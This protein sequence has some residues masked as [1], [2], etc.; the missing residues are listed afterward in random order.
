MKNYKKILIV[1]FVSL[2]MK[3]PG[4]AGYLWN[5]D[6]G[7][8]EFYNNNLEFAKDYFLSYLNNNP[9]DADGYWWL[10]NTLKKL[11][12]KKYLINFKKSYELLSKEKNLEKLGF[13][14]K[15]SANIEDYFDMAT[16]YFDNGNLKEAEFYADMMLRINPKSSS[17]YYIKA[18]V[19]NVMQDDIKAKEYMEKA[20][21]Y[22]NELIKTNLAQSLGITT[23]PQANEK[24]M[25][26]FSLESYF[27]GNLDE[28]IEY[29]KKANEI[30]PQDAEIASTLVNLYFKKRNY[31]PVSKVLDTA[32]KANENNISLLLDKSDLYKIEKN[33]SAQLNTLLKA[34]KINPNNPNVLLAL[35]NFYFENK[36]YENAKKYFETLSIVDD[37]MYEGIFGLAE[38][39][40]NLG[41]IEKAEIEVRKLNKVN[42][43]ASEISYLLSK[44][45][46]SEGNYQEALDYIEEALREDEN[47]NYYLE[48][49]KLY[50]ILKNHKIS[51]QSLDDAQIMPY[52]ANDE[53]EIFE[54][55]IKNYI[56]LKRP[57]DAGNYLNKLPN[58]EKNRII[59]KYDLYNLYKLNGQDDK[60]YELYTE[61][62]RFKPASIQDYIDLSDAFYEMKGPDF[63]IKILDAGLRK[64]PDDK[65]LYF[66]KVKLYSLSNDKEKRFETLKKLKGNSS[67]R[68]I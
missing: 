60:A 21:I 17:A 9:N 55:Y 8:D 12:D 56:K 46:S 11:S 2:M 52:N 35:G 4:T 51:L 41:Q 64:Y 58:E 29:Q 48:E 33:K 28:A 10:A 27:D 23:M 16:M 32:L 1:F 57:E 31:E 39:L 34:Y 5:I 13:N 19:S 36:D 49:A 67:D 14:I 15:N 20:I 65:Q 7:I 47:P 3:A 40:L 45:C 26:L 44:I 62:R 38:S 61:I 66:Q 68:M 22:N 37:S 6:V 63:A 18:G 59:Y 43:N 30:N 54:Y 25:R 42:P 24:E 50:Y 53:N